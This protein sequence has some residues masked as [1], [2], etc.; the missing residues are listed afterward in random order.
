MATGSIS[1][2]IQKI[3]LHWTA[4]DYGW[5]D[6]G[7]YHTVITGEGRIHRL[8]PYEQPLNAHTYARNQ[9]SVS[10]SISCLLDD[11]WHSFPPTPIQIERLCQEVAQLSLSLGWTQDEVTIQ[12]IM[13]HA[14]AAA[15]RDFP[16]EQA[17]LV[18]GWPR[19]ATDEA[20]KEYL[21]RCQSL[22]LPHENYGPSVWFDDWPGGHAER[23]DLWRLKPSDAPGSGGFWLRQ[24]IRQL[25]TTG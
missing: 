8:T 25:L 10:L 7:Y 18:S 23:W 3:Y 6:P 20:E 13:T 22:G 16:L 21:R 2:A 11:D 9:G 24:R 1:Q 15:N 12:R 14:E 17:L 19:P 4:T 5:A